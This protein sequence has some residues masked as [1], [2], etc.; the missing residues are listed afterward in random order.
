MINTKFPFRV[1]LLNNTNIWAYFNSFFLILTRSNFY[2]RNLKL[3]PVVDNI[4]KF[5]LQ[6]KGCSIRTT[7]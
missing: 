4:F 3:E 2:L 6:K 5:K 1:D 7:F